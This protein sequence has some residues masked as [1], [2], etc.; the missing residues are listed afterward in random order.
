[1]SAADQ[2]FRMFFGKRSATAD[3]LSHI[4]EITVEQAMD[5]AWQATIKLFLCLDEKGKWS[6]L[7]DNFLKS[8]ERVRVELQLGTANW[9]PLID[10][11]I[12]ARHGDMDS[13]PGRSNIIL[14][15]NDDSVL[16]N[17]EQE[18]NQS[19]RDN[20]SDIARVLFGKMSE[21]AHKDIE[22]TPDRTDALP[23]TPM[24]RAT[25]MQQLRRLADRNGF[26]AFVL[27]GEKPGESIG[28][29]R[30]DPT[31]SQGLP[32]LVLM[33]RDR[34]LSSL[35]VTDDA[36]GPTRF[37]AS[38]LRI[39]DKRVIPGKSR[40][41]DLDLLGPGPTLL[42]NQI[43]TQLLSPIENDEDD[44]KRALQA[45]TLRSSYSI[46][47]TGSVLPG[48]YPGVLQPYQIVSI[49]AGPTKSSGTYLLTKATHRITPSL[50]IQKFEA[51]RNALAEMSA[52]LAFIRKI[53]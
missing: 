24:Q 28:C 45:A 7:E 20:D 16:L 47:A 26:H 23:P 21:I 39:K 4:E 8:F 25:A 42:E 49:R 19:Q 48:A 9:V 52:V 5:M 41:Q 15:V 1:M 29:F 38:Y 34:N 40:L 18:V 32:D 51:K 22:S 13:E 43:A 37:R 46:H 35:Q 10:G 17:R 53:V 50:Y 14:T 44:P 6:H 27:P 31:R 2:K 3:E 11:P 33:G 36:Q 12:V 30:P